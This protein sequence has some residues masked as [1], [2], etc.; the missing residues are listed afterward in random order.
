MINKN[1]WVALD[2]LVA[3]S[4]V[5]IDRPRGSIHPRYADFSYPLDYG[6]I[7]NT[8]SMDGG[9][10]DVWRG[11]SAAKIDAVICI[12]DLIKRDCEIKILLG[13]TEDEKRIIYPLH[14]QTEFMKGIMIERER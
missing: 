10:I 9:G 5:I 6:Y 14:N 12:V 8:T 3:E 13:C 11:S 2:A 7:E 1:F 4:K